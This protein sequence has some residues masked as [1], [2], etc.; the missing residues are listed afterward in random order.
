MDIV[1]N[2]H[3]MLAAGAGQAAAGES[4]LGQIVLP[5][6]GPYIIHDM[7]AQV[8]RAVATAAELTG[9]Y[10]RL[11]VASGDLTPNPAPSHIPCYSGGSSLG[12]TLNRDNCPLKLHK[13]NYEAAGKA[14]INIIVA[15]DILVNTAPQWVAG[16]I[17]GTTIPEEP[18]FSFID[19]TR[20]LIAAAAAA[21][22][23][24]ITVS[25]KATKIVGVCG[26]LAQ[27]GV[28]V[29]GEEL[30]GFFSMT[31]D[32]VTLPPLQLP[33]ANAWGAGLG[34]LI[35]GDACGPVNLIPVDIP[36][37]GGARINF[38][39]DLNTAVTNAANVAFYLA[40]V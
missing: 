2:T 7:Y 40:Y 38:A 15:N 29:T 37:T 12:A 13:C 28:L 1:S 17:F 21:A 14:V 30:L 16:I 20:G 31:S 18:R 19:S 9:G 23:G 27:S 24:T 32:D 3:A 34:A 5:A 8:A 26:V 10:M 25:Q 11:D 33:F 22:I 39:V 35:A 6:G 4:L 36:V